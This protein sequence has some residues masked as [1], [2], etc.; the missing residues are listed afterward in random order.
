MPANSVTSPAPATLPPSTA[1][2]TL[3][4]Q[5]DESLS[6]LRALPAAAARD[7][8]ARAHL[9]NT[10]ARI[11][12][13]LQLDKENEQLLL[14]CSLTGTRA[15]PS[16]APATSMTC[17]R[18]STRAARETCVDRTGLGCRFK[19]HFR[20]L[21]FGGSAFWLGVAPGL[22]CRWAWAVS[23]VST[24]TP[25]NQ[26]AIA[27]GERND[28]RAAGTA[29]TQCGRASIVVFNMA[30]SAAVISLNPSRRAPSKIGSNGRSWFALRKDSC[31]PQKR[32]A[33]L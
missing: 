6:A 3:L 24:A 13:R 25:T 26:A 30:Y 10:R 9:E 7:R 21:A 1:T 12:Q 28:R 18:K 22:P 2:F 14:Q 8:E 19:T 4:E 11:L 20:L 17:F 32:P 15:T 23:A 33:P 29:E 31:R 27:L 16:A 5:L